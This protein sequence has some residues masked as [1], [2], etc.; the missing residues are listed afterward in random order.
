MK[1]DRPAALRRDLWD[2]PAN[3]FGDDPFLLPK[4]DDDDDDD[5]V[6]AKPKVRRE[7]LFL[8]TCR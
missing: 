8:S 4:E 6:F 5:V 7:V 2:T 1:K 3:E